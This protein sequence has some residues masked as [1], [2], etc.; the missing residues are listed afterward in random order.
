MIC[1]RSAGLCWM[2][3]VQPAWL[4]RPTRA[5]ERRLRR[6]LIYFPFEV[7]MTI[8]RRSFLLTGAGVAAGACY[9][10][11]AAKSGFKIGVTDWNLQQTGKVEAVALAHRIGFDGVEV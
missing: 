9:L 1:A 4:F 11:A 5:S 8:S 2:S 7:V 10:P 3:V 6:H